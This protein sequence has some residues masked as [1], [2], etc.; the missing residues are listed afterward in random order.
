MRAYWTTKYLG[1]KQRVVKLRGG[2]IVEIS[3]YSFDTKFKAN[4]KC[5]ELNLFERGLI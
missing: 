3:E 2:L 5:R 4:I 1:G